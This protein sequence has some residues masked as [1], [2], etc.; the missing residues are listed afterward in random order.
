MKAAGVV[1]ILLKT[2]SKDLF[3]KHK[4]YGLFVLPRSGGLIMVLHTCIR[5]VFFFNLRDNF[6]R[7]SGYIELSWH[8]TA[9]FESSDVRNL[10]V[11][12]ASLI[13]LLC[14]SLGS[15]A[16]I[17]SDLYQVRV[18]VIDQSTASRQSGIQDALQQ[19]LVKVS[20]QVES[21][22][23]EVVQAAASSAERYVKSF[24]YSRDEA[25]DG[26]LLEVLFAQNLID[27][28]LKD[29]QQPVWGKSRPLVLLW[30]GVEDELQRKA[31]NQNSGPWRARLE[32]AMNERGIPLLWP[33]QDLDDE[34]V[35]P[36]ERLWGL[37]KDDVQK[38]SARYA[39]DAFMAGRLAPGRDNGWRYQ[40][41][42]Q[43]KGDWLDL[44]A[45]GDDVNSVLLQ[46]A[47]QVAGFL[48][49]RYA[50][51]SD[52]I[53]GGHQLMIQGV[54]NFRQYHDVISYLN[55]NVAVNSVR[56]LAVNQ[57]DLTLELDLAADWAQVWSTLALDK[58]LLATEQEHVFSW[59]P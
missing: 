45:E 8:N 9:R 39:T 17:V 42:I 38:A 3:M 40:G 2:N 55:A 12:A 43:H 18:P 34:L 21:V 6:G 52:G 50:L 29:A 5:G 33:A 11:R 58:R 46:V 1:R 41:F 31:L 28:L 4:L 24:R 30:Q 19:V 27:A 7:S 15:H 16:V 25:D 54:Q 13:L 37:F 47:D 59:Q 35:L 44:Q 32:R 14:L 20:G 36:V 57:Q 10:P 23:S 26:L 56:V 49:A 22:Q 48:S 53:A 51:R